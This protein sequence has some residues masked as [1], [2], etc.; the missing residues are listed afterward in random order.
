V[1]SDIR[2][3]I[4]SGYYNL[5]VPVLETNH[6]KLVLK[7]DGTGIEKKETQMSARKY[8]LG[9]IRKETLE[10]HQNLMKLR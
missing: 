5:G 9:E 6:T 4:A 2:S 1:K 10:K 3:I 8:P 7:K